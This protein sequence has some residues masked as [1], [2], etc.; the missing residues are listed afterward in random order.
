MKR[1]ILNNDFKIFD[2]IVLAVISQDVYVDD[3]IVIE[4]AN[5]INLWQLLT[6][7]FI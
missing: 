5:N 6:G 2:K 4:E 7:Y 3:R 1:C